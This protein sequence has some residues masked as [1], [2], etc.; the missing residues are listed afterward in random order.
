MHTN[1]PA[2]YDDNTYTNLGIRPMRANVDHIYGTSMYDYSTARVCST[3]NLRLRSLSLSYIFNK[4]VLKKMH[5]S[6]F[7][8]SAQAN[9]LFIIADK[10]W[11]GFD[12]EQGSSAN[13]SI[14]RTY[15]LSVTIGF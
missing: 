14:P 1:I 4:K 3:N 7:Q 13:S 9:N 11:H 10:R 2:L 5:L 8:I 12:P 6:N 15:S